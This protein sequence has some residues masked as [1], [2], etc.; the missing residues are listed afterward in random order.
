MA[1]LNFLT[2]DEIE[3]IRKLLGLSH[4][5]VLI[6]PDWGS[7]QAG[8]RDQIHGELKK[9]MAQ[10]YPLSDSSISHCRNLGGFAFTKYES[11]QMVQLGLDIEEDSRV[12]EA[13]IKRV[14]KSEAEVIRAPSYVS[15]WTAKEAAFK[16]LKGSQQPKVISE[17]EI[18]QWRVLDSH[19]ETASF[20]DIQKFPSSRIV[21]VLIKKS[22]FTLA[23][24]AF[25]P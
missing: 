21:G 1:E 12:S 19:Y 22:G 15:L 9:K 16:A 11:H 14:C 7:E 17:I 20:Q 24:F 4:L 8:H 5:E 3:K 2:A 10:A 18:D 23:F 6:R 13:V 25:F